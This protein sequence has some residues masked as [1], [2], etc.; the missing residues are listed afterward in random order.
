VV[1]TAQ[2]LAR[3]DGGALDI[4]ASASWHPGCT[5]GQTQCC[6]KGRNPFR[7]FIP[8]AVQVFRGKKDGKPSVIVDIYLAATRTFPLGGPTVEC[9]IIQE[10]EF[11][12]GQLIEVSENFSAAAMVAARRRVGTRTDAARARPCLREDR[13]SAACTRDCVR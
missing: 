11:N 9:R 1:W 7:P 3:V 12:G 13:A 6:Y 5:R 4:L 2:V 8:G 10:T